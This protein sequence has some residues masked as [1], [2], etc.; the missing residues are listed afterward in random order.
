MTEDEDLLLAEGLQ[1]GPPWSTSS[2]GLRRS[3]LRIETHWSMPPRRSFSVRSTP[4]GA[5]IVWPSPLE[6]TSRMFV[7]STAANSPRGSRG[8]GRLRSLRTY[9]AATELGATAS[10]AG[11]TWAR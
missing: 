11:P 8:R 3:R 10:M 5:T 1:P 2:T 6:I 7:D 4:S 9:E